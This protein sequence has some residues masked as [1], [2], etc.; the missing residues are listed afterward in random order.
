MELLRE[1]YEKDIG[2]KSCEE[3]QLYEVRKAAR[4]IVINHKEQM[5]LL[6][7]SKNNYHK[8]PGGGLEKQENIEEAL[9]RE[10]L[11]E[12]GVKGEIIDEVGVIIEYRSQFKLLHISYCYLVQVIN[13]LEKPK[14]T[15][16]EISNGFELKW[17]GIEE[18][19]DVLK[20]DK[21]HDYVGKFIQERD[22][23][24]LSS[25]KKLIE[26]DCH[27]RHSSK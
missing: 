3:K 27:P 2:I 5:A 19:L 15:E 12:V 7:V 22:L 1:I 24:F 6:F 16:D 8:L 23:T 20:S 11:E 25:A 18:A 4:A 17:I 21:P 9:G 14:F 13:E 10:I 26:S